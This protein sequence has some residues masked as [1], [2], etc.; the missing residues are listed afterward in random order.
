MLAGSLAADVLKR[1]TMNTHTGSCLCGSVKFK[2]EGDFDHFF[3]CH[4]QYCQKDTGSAHGANLFSN[5][6]ILKWISGE[7]KIK[8]YVLPSTRHVKSFCTDCGSALPNIQIDGKLIVVPAGSLDDSLS[9]KPTAHIFISSKASW[10]VNLEAIKK[11]EYL[12]NFKMH[13]R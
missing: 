10:E 13:Q 8:T 9:M 12:P 2:V 6:A 1:E 3:L 7:D 5:T 4:C 11:F